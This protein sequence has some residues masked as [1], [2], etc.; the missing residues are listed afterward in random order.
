MGTNTKNQRLKILDDMLSQGVW[1]TFSDFCD[2]ADPYFNK[3]NKGLTDDEAYSSNF[4][5]DI[6][7]IRS[8]LKDPRNSL[9]PEML[10]TQGPKRKM[11]YRY[12][13][14]GFSI[15][16]Y[17]EYQYTAADYKNLTHALKILKGNLPDNVFENLDFTVRSRI[18]YDYSK[19][20]D[21]TVD[22]GEN[23]RLAGRHWLPVLYKAVCKTV[24][25]ITYKTYEGVSYSYQLH[26]Y[27][28]KLFN[29]RWFIFG[30]HPEKKQSYWSVPL[31]RIQNVTLL[32]EKLFV[33]RPEQYLSRFDSLIGV[34]YA[35]RHE[36]KLKGASPE[37]ITLGFHRNDAW[38]RS[39]TKPLHSSQKIVKEFAEGYGEMSLYVVPN[40]EFFMRVLLQGEC[41]S[42][43]GP[44]HIRKEMASIIK[45]LNGRYSD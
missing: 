35:S 36:L 23:L 33:P 43:V 45:T 14:K 1:I 32:P 41:V 15:I 22:Y 3:R 8:I 25:D 34:T 13:V 2:K 27:L 7:I 9:D 21:V 16:P 12:K 17:L 39:I 18:E 40:N 24:L 29:Q 44:D 10:Q 11:S 28:L 6:H 37:L 38:L 19:K 26:P 30:F 4:R 42:I 31:D 20:S 5:S